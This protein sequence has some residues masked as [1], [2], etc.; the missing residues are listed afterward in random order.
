MSEPLQPLADDY[1][2]N[3]D[4]FVVEAIE[5]GVVWGLAT[6]QGDWALVDSER[7]DDVE[8]MPFWSDQR[9]AQAL[10]NGEWSVYSP[11]AIDL[12]EF[13]DEW[14]PGLHSDVV[15]VGVNWDE[16]LVGEEYEPLDL[17]EELEADLP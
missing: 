6:E 12:E 14:L 3:L 5:S 4:R 1:E 8:V 7:S 2:E 15:L 11:V 10:C 17:S 9:L 13:L 16:Q